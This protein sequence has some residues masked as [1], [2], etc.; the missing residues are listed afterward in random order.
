MDGVWERIYLPSESYE[1]H[2]ASKL[3]HKMELGHTAEK[4]ISWFRKKFSNPGLAAFLKSLAGARALCMGA[5]RGAEVYVLRQ[6]GLDAIGID[7]NPGST[8]PDSFVVKELQGLVVKGDCLRAP[9]PDGHFSLVYTNSLDHMRPLMTFIDESCRL[10][11]NNGLLI[12]RIP[13]QTLA[14][15]W[16]ALAWTNWEYLLRFFDGKFKRVSAF[17]TSFPPLRGGKAMSIVLKRK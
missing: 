17:P 8:Q 9:W 11:S 4:T 1:A 10:L 7:L 6:L 13:Q 3:S 15:R 16:E 14:G 12:L 5:R 2:Q